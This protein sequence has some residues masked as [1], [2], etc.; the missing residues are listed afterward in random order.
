MDGDEGAREAI[1]STYATIT[2]LVQEATDEEKR[3]A[4]AAG[5]ASSLLWPADAEDVE[6]RYFLRCLSDFEAIHMHLLAVAKQGQAV[7]APILD[8]SGPLS[9]NAQAAWSE[10]NDRGMV[11]P[12]LENSWTTPLGTRF[13]H[14]IGREG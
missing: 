2:R 6:R 10:L 9:E 8:A 13:L 11:H 5:M 7:V 1:L 12:G 4:L 14:F 3:Q